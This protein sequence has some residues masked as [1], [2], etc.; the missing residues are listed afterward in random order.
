[1]ILLY[2]EDACKSAILFYS[3]LVR[4]LGRA[5]A[6][7]SMVVLAVTPVVCTVRET[8]ACSSDHCGVRYYRCC[9]CAVAFLRNAFFC[10]LLLGTFIVPPALMLLLMVGIEI[11]C[12]RSVKKTGATY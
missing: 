3:S 9:G 10:C 1:M 5:V 6:A 4:R 8:A 12:V 11:E 2:Q 7:C